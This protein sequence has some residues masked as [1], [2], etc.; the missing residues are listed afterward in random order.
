V[1]RHHHVR[2]QHRLDLPA[3]RRLTLD[4]G[5]WLSCDDCFDQ[6]DRAAEDVVLR[7]RP[8]SAAF[9]SHLVG[10]PACHEE[11]QS[12]VAV[13]AEGVGLDPVEAVRRLERQLQIAEGV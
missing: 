13:V 4:A 7:R 11:A 8:L 1:T 12:L 6:V 2:P 10:C 5:V 3:A 9:R